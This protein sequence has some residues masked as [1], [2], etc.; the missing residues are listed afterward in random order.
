MLNTMTS[1]AASKGEAEEMDRETK[2]D[3]SLR[4]IGR[5]EEVAK[6]VAFLLSHESSYISGASVGI[7]GGWNC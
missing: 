2:I 3:V 4:R 1:R 5:P 6:L 7:D